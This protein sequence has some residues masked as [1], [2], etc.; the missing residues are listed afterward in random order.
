MSIN[1]LH[2]GR[3]K[4]ILADIRSEIEGMQYDTFMDFYSKDGKAYIDGIFD[5]LIEWH[6]PD[7]LIEED[8]D[9]DLIMDWLRDEEED[10]NYW[11]RDWAKMNGHIKDEPDYDETYIDLYGL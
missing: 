10:L 11:A 7:R 6:D 2:R 9:V 8:N 3:V 5:Q 4:A 1:E